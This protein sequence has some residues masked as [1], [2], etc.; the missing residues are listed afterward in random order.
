MINGKGTVDMEIS[1]TKVET[2][3]SKLVSFSQGEGRR[4][5]AG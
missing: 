5:R 4:Y 3:L 1:I 2:K